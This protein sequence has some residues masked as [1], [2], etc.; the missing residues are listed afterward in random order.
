[1]DTQDNQS[2][3]QLHLASRGYGYFNMAQRLEGCRVAG[4]AWHQCWQADAADQR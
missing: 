4:P 2:R 3:P 1:M